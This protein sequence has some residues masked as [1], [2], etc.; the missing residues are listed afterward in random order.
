MGLWG[1]DQ[2]CVVFLGKT[3]YSHSAV[4]YQGVQ[5]GWRKFLGKS[6]EMQGG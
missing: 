2:C 3:L 4:F 6:D 5:I 1:R